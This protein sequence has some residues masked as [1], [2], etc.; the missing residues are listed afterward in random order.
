MIKLFVRF[1]A[2]VRVIVALWASKHRAVIQAPTPLPIE[3]PLVDLSLKILAGIAARKYPFLSP[4]DAMERYLV[5]E[6]N[7]GFYFDDVK[8]EKAAEQK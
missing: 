1:L 7:S 5:E 3:R 8:R 2:R 4:D 6:A